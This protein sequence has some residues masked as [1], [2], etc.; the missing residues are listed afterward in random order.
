MSNFTLPPR[1]SQAPQSQQAIYFTLQKNTKGL[2]RSALSK[3][4]NYAITTTRDALQ[5]LAK[6]GLIYF[7]KVLR[8]WFIR[9]IK[10]KTEDIYDAYINLKKDWKSFVS[11]VGGKIMKRMRWDNP[12]TETFVY[13]QELVE[14]DESFN[15]KRGREGLPLMK[16]IPT[17][18]IK[19]AKVKVVSKRK[20]KEKIK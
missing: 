12:H 8:C 16:R 19:A 10:E 11:R 20:L 1:I 5:A 13:S 17:V 9:T 2:T 18:F 15:V 3:A 7:N 14:L 6:K 4:S